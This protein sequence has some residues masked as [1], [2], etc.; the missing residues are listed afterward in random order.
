M[1]RAL[2]LA[3]VLG[4][5]AP[6]LAPMPAMAVQPDEILDDPALESR[7]RAL[8]ANLRCV[9][10]QNESIDDSNAD[11]ARDMRLAVR[12]RLVEGD[13]DAQVMQFMVERYGEFV[14]L[15]PRRDGVN[16]ILWASAPIMLL[17]GLGMAFFAIRRRS[18]ETAAPLSEEERARLDEILKR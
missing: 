11:L 3:L 17:L 7:A 6:G 9:V 1:L 13:S 8:S 2:A 15:S 10:C 5:A 16:M 14:L 12:E 4:L 18:A